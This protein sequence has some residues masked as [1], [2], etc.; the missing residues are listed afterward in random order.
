MGTPFRLLAGRCTPRSHAVYRC[1]RWEFADFKP[2]NISRATGP[3]DS[4]LDPMDT[5]CA[6][7]PAAARQ[8]T[9]NARSIRHQI[10]GSDSSG[11]LEQHRQGSGVSKRADHKSVRPSQC[12]PI[13]QFPF[14]H[15]T[16]LIENREHMKQPPKMESVENRVY[17][18][19][20]FA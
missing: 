19:N 16:R 7:Y 13:L 10:C 1:A 3:H 6:S 5:A 15:G 4:K 17:E 9:I 11:E 20:T 12:L 18:S 8:R 14:Q 2:A